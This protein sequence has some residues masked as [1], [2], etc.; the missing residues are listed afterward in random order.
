MEG[1]LG[2]CLLEIASKLSKMN[3]TGEYNKDSPVRESL[4]RD[5]KSPT[6]FASFASTFYF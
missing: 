2:S 3:I 6:F 1:K 5:E 4:Q